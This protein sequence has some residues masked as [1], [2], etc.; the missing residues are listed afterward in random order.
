MRRE[1]VEQNRVEARTSLRVGGRP[2]EGSSKV[3]LRMRDRDQR[4]P[5][6]Y[7]YR[8]L[9][10]QLQASRRS[11]LGLEE[12]SAL[13]CLSLPLSLHLVSSPK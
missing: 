11:L 10:E 8:T 3:R 7:S 5:D 4:A 1:G 9:G 12:S 2:E 13:L 6:G